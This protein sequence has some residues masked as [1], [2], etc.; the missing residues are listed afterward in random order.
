MVS[1]DSAIDAT[2]RENPNDTFSTDA[3]HSNIVKFG[4][5]TCQDYLN[6]S[7]RIV[8]LVENAPSVI[9]K[10]FERRGERM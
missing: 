2:P 10:R 4:S 7:A 6:V 5:S 9:S 8:G 1:R 3:N